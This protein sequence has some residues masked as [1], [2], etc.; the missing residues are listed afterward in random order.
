KGY[1]FGYQILMGMDVLHT[2]GIIHR[3]LKP[4]NILID[5]YGNIKIG[6]LYIE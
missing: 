1:S 3:D 6:L 4:E 5:K 2:Q